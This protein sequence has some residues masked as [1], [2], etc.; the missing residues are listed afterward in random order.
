MELEHSKGL[1]SRALT[2]MHIVTFSR[3]TDFSGNRSLTQQ[4]Q[5]VAFAGCDLQNLINFVCSNQD[6]LV[7]MEI[8]ID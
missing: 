8:M 4:A 1:L 6:S 2:H 7:V 5:K 3:L